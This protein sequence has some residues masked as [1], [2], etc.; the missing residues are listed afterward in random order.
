MRPIG[1]F[2]R[3]EYGCV[4]NKK[5]V[6]AALGRNPRVTGGQC[7]SNGSQSVAFDDNGA[8]YT[9]DTTNVNRCYEVFL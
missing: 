6:T 1:S 2:F 9:P 5:A 8:E 7:M 4:E 3:A